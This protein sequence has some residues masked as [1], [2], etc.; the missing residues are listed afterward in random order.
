MKS[1]LAPLLVLFFD[2]C[3]ARLRNIIR[4]AR[5]SLRVSARSFQS[6]RLSNRM[7][8]LHRQSQ[9]PDGHRFGFE[10]TFFRQA[11]KREA[12]KTQCLGRSRPVPGPSRAERSRRRTILSR[13][14]AQSLRPGIA[15]ADPALETLERQLAGAIGSPGQH[16]DAIA[17]NFAFNSPLSPQ[18]PPVIHGRN[19]VSQKVGRRGPRLPLHFV[20]AAANERLHRTR[21]ERPFGSKAPRG[22]TTSSSAHQLGRTRADG[23]GSA[24]NSTTTPS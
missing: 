23:T 14:T 24:S 8:V 6:S 9:A 3:P 13:G 22:W 15:G 20:H 21:R 7:V 1:M 16:L 11:V 19:G 5:L 10:L 17:D 12:E 4:V 18:K 2:S